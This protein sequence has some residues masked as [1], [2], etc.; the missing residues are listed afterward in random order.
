MP[1][2]RVI[3]SFD[4]VASSSARRGTRSGPG[5]SGD[6]GPTQPAV[7]VEHKMLLPEARER[8]RQIRVRDDGRE[9]LALQAEPRIEKLLWLGRRRR[10]GRA[11]RRRD[12]VER[13]ARE[14]EPVG[15]QPHGL[16]ALG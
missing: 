14:I 13:L 11:A 8:V 12:P 4:A 6:Q 1:V 10:L 3:P 16:L 15:D 5:H 7:L 2:R 9:C